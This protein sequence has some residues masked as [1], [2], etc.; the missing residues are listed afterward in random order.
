MLS[1]L[2][3]NSN[4][5]TCTNFS[6]DLD[7]GKNGS[8]A[9][10]LNPVVWT[11]Q[12]L[13]AN[14]SHYVEG[15]VVPYRAILSGLDSGLCY[16]IQI[17][18][19][20]RHSGVNALDY[21]T[22]YP[23]C[24]NTLCDDPSHQGSF[25]HDAE[26]VDPTDGVNNFVTLTTNFFPIPVPTNNMI[27]LGLSQPQTSFNAQEAGE[28]NLTMFNGLITS[29]TYLTQGSL[30]AN[31]SATS[32]QLCFIAQGDEAI[33]AWGGH[34]ASR[35]EWGLG[36]S[37]GSISGA[38]YHMRVLGM[39]CCHQTSFTGGNQDRSLQA[40]AVI[41][42][43][44]AH[45]VSTDTLCV[46]G[47]NMHTVTTNDPG[48]STYSWQITNAGTTGAQIIGISTNQQI[49]VSTSSA[50]EYIICGTITINGV[51]DSDCDT[52]TVVAA[53][54][55]NIT[56]DS[57]VC[58]GASAIFTASGGDSYL[59][60]TGETTASIEVSST[61]IYTVTVSEAFGCSISCQK[62]L[63][64]AS[65]FSLDFDVT[66]VFCF[67]DATGAINLN[68]VGGG[69]GLIFDWSNGATSEDI[70]GL[71][72]GT[73]TVTVTD[74]NGCS[75]TG[76]AEIVQPD[77]A[78]EV[79]E[80]HLDASCFDGSDGSID[81]TI[82]GGTAPYEVNWSNNST[83]EDLTGLSEGTYSVVVTDFFG[84][85]AGFS[86]DIEEPT[87]IVIDDTQENVAC[88]GGNDGSI[89]ISV[90]GGTPGYDYLWEDNSTAEDRTGLS[91]GTYTVTVTDD[92]GCT[93][94]ETYF[95]SQA[96]TLEL[97]E[98]HENVSCFEGNDGSIDLTV[99]GGTPGYT[100][101]W[102]DG[103]VSDDR[104]T[105]AA[106][107]YTVT[108]SDANGCSVVESIVITEPDLLEV[109]EFHEDVDCFG[110]S[111]GSI[112]LTVN[113]GVDPY[114]FIW[115]NGSTDEDL[116]G[117][118]SG[119][120]TVTVTDENG[121]SVTESIF[122]DQPTELLITDSD[123]TD[124]S[125]YGGSN[126]AIDITVSGGT[127]DYIFSWSNGMDT[128][129]ISGLTM[130]SY[131]VNIV[132][133]NGCSAYMEFEVDEPTLL[134]VS[135]TNIDITCFDAN[136]GSI[137]LTV[138]G[139]T[140]NY[141]YDWSNG[142]STEDI[143]GLAAGTYTVIVTDGNGCTATLSV[144]ITQ[145]LLLEVME[146]HSDETCNESNNGSINLGVMGGT[147]DYS[148]NWSNGETTQDISGLVAG[149]YTVTVTDD[150][151]CTALPAQLLHSPMHWQLMS[152]L[153]IPFAEEPAEQLI[154]Q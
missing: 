80:T 119:T 77:A 125:C 53:P 120:Y 84:C 131:N 83:D 132:D 45:V 143:S 9:N 24:T 13:N 107:M 101:L 145:P 138:T 37:A 35:L 123:I 113:G 154:L 73:Y 89:D 137:D 30:V 23:N 52:I 153:P 69:V 140:L 64:A 98:T 57:L 46:G 144:E 112:N 151:G 149:T 1:L 25:L 18:W 26:C 68:I 66:D 7:Q 150:N 152:R 19:D 81:L 10:P 34:I 91:A 94:T 62:S 97:D 114:S 20:I 110:N 148:Y 117:L 63:T 104:S 147:P 126:G 124:V 102:N 55:C 142:A 3:I 95:I 87:Q 127:P 65:P 67:G 47:T 78:L 141:S 116:T 85:T 5:Q 27:A 21:I 61:G 128:E 6:Y 105:L 136:N 75:V 129:D 72:A 38:P 36:N 4:A 22:S 54:V 59:W 12:N 43:P 76:S 106:T 40:G 49:Q 50:G 56:G 111:N 90:S 71:T 48:A 17:E 96:G 88:N 39:K 28:T 44:V 32:L 109:S 86:V 58:N 29:A 115:N 82:T 33:L 42:A 146:A 92:N 103:S 93:A 2:A 60:S 130:G 51:S 108:V 135:E 41:P 133:A 14:A 134:E 16:C 31:Q 118:I 8:S 122:I 100:Y 99:S 11:N 74:E 139:G 79:N 15:H 70:S 121:C